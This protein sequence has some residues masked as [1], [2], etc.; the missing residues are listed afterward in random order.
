MCADVS[1][2]GYFAMFCAGLH[3]FKILHMGWVQE[4]KESRKMASNSFYSERTCIKI[5]NNT[6]TR[7]VETYKS[8][9]LYKNI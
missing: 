3:L 5:I 4:D 9:N 6:W 2:I 7:Q 1:F 8:H